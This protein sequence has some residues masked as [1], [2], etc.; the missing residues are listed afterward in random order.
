MQIHKM[1]FLSSKNNFK[2]Q[3]NNIQHLLKYEIFVNTTVGNFTLPSFSMSC[4]RW[5]SGLFSD[6]RSADDFL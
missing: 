2:K 3:I 6:T 1:P 4:H 5:R